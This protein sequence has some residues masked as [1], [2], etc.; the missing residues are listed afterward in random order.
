MPQCVFPQQRPRPA[1]VRMATHRAFTEADPLKS[2]W[3]HNRQ[4]S[5]L[6]SSSASFPTASSRAQITKW[7]VLMRSLEQENIPKLSRRCLAHSTPSA[8]ADAAVA[9]TP[10][11]LERRP[12]AP[13]ARRAEERRNP[14]WPPGH[15]RYVDE[16]HIEGGRPNESGTRRPRRCIAPMPRARP[17]TST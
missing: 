10:R 13:Y 14:Q 9:V 6:S 17:L 16:P 15:V 12:R 5:A 7:Y 1:L 4:P 8:L 2:P 11:S 3:S